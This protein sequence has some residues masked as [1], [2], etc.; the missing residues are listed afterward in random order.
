MITLREEI[1]KAQYVRNKFSL[2]QELS[3]LRTPQI[4]TNPEYKLKYAKLESDG[5]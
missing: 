3:C 2:F 1:R 5:K 4:Q